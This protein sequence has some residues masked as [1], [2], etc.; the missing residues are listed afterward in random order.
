MD[1]NV[2]SVFAP[3]RAGDPVEAAAVRPWLEQHSDELFLSVVTVMELQAGIEKAHR[4]G[5]RGADLLATWLDTVLGSY[6]ERVL[7][8]DIVVA[9][10]AGVMADDARARGRDPS[11][12]D[13]I[14]PPAVI[15]DRY[16][17]IAADR[18]RGWF[19]AGR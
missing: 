9:R 5:R 18:G 16:A 3:G 10:L 7:P 2:I 13:T 8:L 14:I 17:P 1:T 11:V 4:T 15:I 12:A 6:V 19:R